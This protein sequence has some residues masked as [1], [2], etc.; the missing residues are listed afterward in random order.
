MQR[1]RKSGDLK[2]DAM[3]V[4]RMLLIPFVVDTNHCLLHAL[5]Q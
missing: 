2:L 5:S 3:N 1:Q 4:L